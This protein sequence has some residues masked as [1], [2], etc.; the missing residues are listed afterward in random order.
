M[1]SACSL[2]LAACE[3]SP[4]L[5]AVSALLAD[6]ALL[7]GISLPLDLPLAPS[8]PLDLLSAWAVLAW[9]SPLSVRDSLRLP[10]LPSFV[11]IFRRV[12]C[13]AAS[14]LPRLAS[15]QAATSKGSTSLIRCHNQRA[16]FGHA[17][18]LST[19]TPSWAAVTLSLL[20]ISEDVAVYSSLS[21]M[22]LIMACATG[23]PSSVAWFC[24]RTTSSQSFKNVSAPHPRTS[25]TVAAYSPQSASLG[26]RDN[27]MDGL[28]AIAFE[29]MSKSTPRSLE[30]S[31]S[32]RSQR[33]SSV[34]LSPSGIRSNSTTRERSRTSPRSVGTLMPL[35]RTTRRSSMIKSSSSV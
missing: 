13:L 16:D 30:C 23:D 33:S 14:S 18:S 26:L 21:S 11:G 8:L 24:V 1:C 32:K 35:R 22:N 34:L 10:S 31:S 2:A 7:S 19:S 29:S 9:V 4:Y 15:M 25:Y 5:L 20:C 12:I 6:A 28:S 27:L 17:L 3:K